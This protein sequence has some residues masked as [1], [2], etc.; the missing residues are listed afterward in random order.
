[1][2]TIEEIQNSEVRSLTWKQPFGSLMIHADKQETRVWDTKYRGLTLILAGLLPYP[3]YE[4]DQLCGPHNVNEM[5]AVFN[6]INIS[7]IGGNWELPRGVAIGIGRLVAV[8]PATDFNGLRKNFEDQTYVLWKDKL[9]MH[10]YHDVTPIEHIKWKGH[11]GWRVLT[12]EQKY[13]IKPL[14]HE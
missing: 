1:M 6:D 10:V 7:C 12:N 2:I 13:L 4:L 8:I 9:F 5:F 14:N 11:Q 3:L